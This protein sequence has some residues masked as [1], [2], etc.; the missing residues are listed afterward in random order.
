[1][2]SSNFQIND[3]FE[4]AILTL[5]DRQQSVFRM[6]RL[7]G[8]TMDEIASKLEIS[9]YTVKNHL[10]EATRKIKGLVKP[11]YFMLLVLFF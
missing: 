1:M 11:E 10:A 5:P 2:V 3:L 6:N 9:P 7:E 8:L 4:Q